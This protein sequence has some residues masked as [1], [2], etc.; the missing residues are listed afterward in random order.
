MK[1]HHLQAKSFVAL[2]PNF[3]V[4]KHFG[5]A[6]TLWTKKQEGLLPFTHLH[7]FT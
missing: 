6:V 2:A 4:I 5:L 7:S 1:I 3:N